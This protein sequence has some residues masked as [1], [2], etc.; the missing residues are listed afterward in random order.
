MIL[1]V[2]ALFLAVKAADISQSF[3]PDHV[4]RRSTIWEWCDCSNGTN[5]ITL[6]PSHQPQRNFTILTG[7][8][9]WLKFEDSVTRVSW[10]CDGMKTAKSSYVNVTKD[11]WLSV[12][13]Y[14]ET[15]TGINKKCQQKSGR[16]SFNAW[17]KTA[18]ISSIPFT[19]NT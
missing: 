7:S 5:S 2:L 4:Q 8:I 3:S 9:Q 14:P 12:L 6:W 16:I 15:K 17:N 10:K 11:E 19:S 18:Y 13:L 1:V